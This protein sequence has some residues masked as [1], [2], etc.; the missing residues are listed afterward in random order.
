MRDAQGN[1]M[2]VYTHTASDTATFELTEQHIYGSSR[3]GMVKT[4]IDMLVTFTE[5]NYFYRS[6]G[7]KRYE[8]SNH[9]GNVLSVISDRRLAFD[10]DANGTTNYYEADVMSAQ[11][12][13]PFGMLLVGR[14]W[15]VSYRYGFNDMENDNEVKGNNNAIDFGGRSIYD[16]RIGRFLSVDPKWRDFPSM[17]VYVFAADNPIYFIDVDGAGPGPVDKPYTYIVQ[18]GDSPSTIAEKFG[19]NIDEIMAAN[20]DRGV[21]PEG[22]Y[23]TN[24]GD[25][26]YAEY[27]GDGQ[28]TLWKLNAGDVIYLVS[29]EEL[30]AT[31]EKAEADISAKEIASEQATDDIKMAILDMEIA[32]S[33]MPEWEDIYNLCDS[34]RDLKEWDE[35]N[36]KNAAFNIATGGI[37]KSGNIKSTI[38]VV[39]DIG[40]AAKSGRG[41]WVLTKEGASS[42]KN[43]KTFGTF[44]KSSSD[45]LWWAVD[46]AGHG[47]SKFKV[48]KQTNKGLE[49][50]ADADEFGD[51]IPN[52]HKGSTGTFIPWGQ[53][54]TIK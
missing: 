7:E 54:S 14:N 11:D 39:D 22:S 35:Q 24:K 38:G 33:T 20:F 19:M 53:L 48:Y 16:P 36:K 2:A 51:F 31:I 3:I 15:S 49:W 27:W 13:D 5:D 23:F 44:Y 17:S 32:N 41:L 50:V 6:L 47:G 4:N 34:W 8:L 28:N 42:I 18:Q 43:H 45:D 25:L 9:L 29:V 40:D 21:L 46:N 26:T 52:K 30:Y 10:T 12:Y 37:S 1:V